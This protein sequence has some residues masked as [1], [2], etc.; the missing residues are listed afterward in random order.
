MASYG[1]GWLSQFFE[2]EF[3][4][5]EDDQRIETSNPIDCFQQYSL[6]GNGCHKSFTEEEGLKYKKLE[7]RFG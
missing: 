1:F 6:V 2:M 3:A 7:V 4:I 5:R